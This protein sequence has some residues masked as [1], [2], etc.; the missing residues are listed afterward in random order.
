MLKV[1]LGQG[2]GAAGPLVRINRV[3]GHKGSATEACPELESVSPCGGARTTASLRRTDMIADG[4][5]A[6]LYILYAA[7]LG[8][9][10]AS[11]LLGLQKGPKV[12][13]LVKL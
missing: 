8:H 5:C 4:N 7:R 2:Y 12:A 13:V 11:T 6:V 3:A 9:A 10:V 1:D